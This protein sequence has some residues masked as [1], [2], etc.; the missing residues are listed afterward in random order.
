M[1]ALKTFTVRLN[2]KGA[3]NH[4]VIAYTLVR[5]K[6]AIP[7][8]LNGSQDSIIT[9][10]PYYHLLHIIWKTSFGREPDCL[11]AIIEKYRSG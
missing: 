7:G 5:E 6:K 2:L 3:V 8:M 1:S 11:G 9:N 4:E 10:D